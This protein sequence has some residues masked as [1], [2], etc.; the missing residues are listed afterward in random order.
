MGLA[1]S[2]ASLFFYPIYVV[3]LLSGHFSK[4]R[5]WP[6]NRGRTVATNAERNSIFL[7]LQS[8]T[9]LKRFTL[10]IDSKF[11]RFRKNKNVFIFFRFRV[12]LR[13]ASGFQHCFFLPLNCDL[14]KFNLVFDPAYD[15]LG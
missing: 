14:N 12:C 15:S 3:P 1:A 7:I 8:L 6:L 4:S 10:L 9:R 5:G 13:T 11:N 2:K